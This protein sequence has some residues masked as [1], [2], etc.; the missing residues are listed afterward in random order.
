MDRSHHLAHPPL[1]LIRP[2]VEVVSILSLMLGLAF[3]LMLTA[4]IW[5]ATPEPVRLMH[6]APS[7]IL[8]RGGQSL[9]DAVPSI[10]PELMLALELLAV[11]AV[12]LWVARA[13]T[14]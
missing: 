6:L 11:G 5:A 4:T 2:A 8:V 12:G 10:A 1:G 3:L 14:R 9:G 7:A 13:I